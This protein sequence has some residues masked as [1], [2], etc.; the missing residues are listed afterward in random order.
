MNM[1]FDARGRLWVTGSIEY[2]Y[3]APDDRPAR[4]TIRIL[5]DTDGDGR[6]DKVTTFAD[7]LNIPI[8]LYP[9]KN[10]VDRLQHPEHRALRGHRRRRPGRPPRGPL[11]PVRAPTATRT[12]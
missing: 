7:G 12:A 11:R 1:A 6:A 10:G 8:G 3:P 2:P 4:D 5:E 9:Y